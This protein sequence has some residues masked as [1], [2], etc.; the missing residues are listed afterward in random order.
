MLVG[1]RHRQLL[2]RPFN[3]S[4]LHAALA[5]VRAVRRSDIACASL[6]CCQFQVKLDLCLLQLNTLVIAEHKDSKL[7][8]G[9]LNTIAAASA[10]GQ[11]DVS[12]LVAGSSVEPVSKAVQ[13]VTGVHKVLLADDEN[14]SHQLAEPLSELLVILQARSAIVNNTRHVA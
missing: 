5:Q 10:L 7:A 9:T 1:L 8:A 11:G 13:S 3:C 12:V 2:A 6:H 14:L 4:F